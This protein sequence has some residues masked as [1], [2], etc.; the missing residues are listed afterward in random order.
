MS[1]KHQHEKKS[2]RQQKIWLARKKNK[3]NKNIM[4]QIHYIK[5][6]QVQKIWYVQ[7][8]LHYFQKTYSQ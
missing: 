1:Q 3:Q 5:I 6:H 4:S 8:K 7:Y 2:L